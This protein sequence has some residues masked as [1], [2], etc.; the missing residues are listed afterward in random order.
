MYANWYDMIRCLALLVIHSEV[1]YDREITVHKVSIH[2]TQLN[3]DE[4]IKSGNQHCD[5]V[6]V[7]SYARKFYTTMLCM[8]QHRKSNVSQ[9]KSVY[10]YAEHITNMRFA[11]NTVY[12]NEN[13]W[14]IYMRIVVWSW[15]EHT[16]THSNKWLY[17]NKYVAKKSTSS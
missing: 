11:H 6:C 16:E 9:L 13:K 8:L 3:C 14:R 2:F 10:F 7:V 15:M 1:N 5:M 12:A 17:S 4:C